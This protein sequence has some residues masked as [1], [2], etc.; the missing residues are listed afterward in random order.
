MDVISVSW[1]NIA[2]KILGIPIIEEY[3]VQMYSVPT[4]SSY[5]S[6]GLNFSIFSA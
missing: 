5:N 2:R 6:S 1:K 3:P 4:I